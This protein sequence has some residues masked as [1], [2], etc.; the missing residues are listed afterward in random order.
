MTSQSAATPGD[1]R[2]SE[3]SVRALCREVQEHMDALKRALDE[4]I[5]TYPTPIPR[6]DAQFNNLYDERARLAGALG[7]LG[8]QRG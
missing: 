3:S 7:R 4:E 6:C 8:L 1:A 2:A 5:R